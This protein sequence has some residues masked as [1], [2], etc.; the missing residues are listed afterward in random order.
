MTVLSA[1]ANTGAG[2]MSIRTPSRGW[3]G[4]AVAPRRRL[5]GPLRAAAANGARLRALGVRAPTLAPS[6]DLNKRIG[7]DHLLV[8]VVFNCWRPRMHRRRAQTRTATTVPLAR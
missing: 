7:T 6:A 5:A 8:T 2:A 1:A 4:P 3:V